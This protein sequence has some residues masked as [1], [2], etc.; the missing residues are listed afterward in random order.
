MYSEEKCVEAHNIYKEEE[1]YMY[2]KIYDYE[3]ANFEENLVKVSVPADKINLC[4]SSL[5]T[6]PPSRP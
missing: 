3:K 5:T 1:D 2:R 6:F 4:I